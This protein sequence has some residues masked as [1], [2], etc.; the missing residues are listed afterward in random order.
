MKV[1]EVAA[2]IIAHEGRYLIARGRPALILAGSGVSRRKREAGETLEECFTPGIREELN[3]RIGAPTPFQIVRHEYPEKVVE[4][5]F[6][7][8][9]RERDRGGVGLC[10]SSM[11]L[12]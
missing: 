1:I 4:L 6:L 7:L 5:H 10:G 11:G 8:P 2:G 9:D 12:S 3:I